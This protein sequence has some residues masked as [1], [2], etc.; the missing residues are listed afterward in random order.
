[1]AGPAAASQAMK[2]SSVASPP[3]ADG[4]M[5]FTYT[6]SVTAA[7]PTAPAV[8]GRLRYRAPRH[9]MPAHS[10][11]RL[12]SFQ[13]GR[14]WRILLTMAQ[15]TSDLKKEGCGLRRMT[16]RAILKYLPVPTAVEALGRTRHTRF[17]AFTRDS[18]EGG[19][20]TIAANGG[21][22]RAAV[23][24]AVAFEASKTAVAGASTIATGVVVVAAA[25]GAAV[26][27]VDGDAMFKPLSSL[28][29]CS[30]CSPAVRSPSSNARFSRR[31]DSS[32]ASSMDGLAVASVHSDGSTAL[33]DSPTMPSPIIPEGFDERILRD[34]PQPDPHRPCSSV[35]HDQDSISPTSYFTP[36][37]AAPLHGHKPH[38]YQKA[39]GAA[40][41]SS[42][43]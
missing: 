4:N 41:A 2:A 19:D 10:K 36:S 15:N 31:S 13:G 39:S 37:H 1:M 42:V 6:A 26:L 11:L 5:V 34:A 35:H 7:M 17:P 43:L 9:R 3:A 12:T 38:N 23:P 27:A 25:A 21:P 30:A 32:D 22:A 28:R 18:V 8:Q 33:V 14:A 20:G 29:F 16:R 40:R 24:A